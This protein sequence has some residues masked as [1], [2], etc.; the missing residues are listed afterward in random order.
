METGLLCSR[1]F[2]LHLLPKQS[3]LHLQLYL[4]GPWDDFF[5]AGLTGYTTIGTKRPG[6]GGGTGAKRPGGALARLR[7][8]E[9]I[10]LRSELE[11]GTY[12]RCQLLLEYCKQ[13]INFR[14]YSNTRYQLFSDSLV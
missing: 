14:I 4:S 10:R 2:L 8:K 12:K 1:G 11:S 6:E 7:C 3:L 5:S 13:E 9:R